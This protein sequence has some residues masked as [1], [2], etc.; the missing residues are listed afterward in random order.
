[1]LPG[2]FGKRSWTSGSV[3]VEEY[4]AFSGRR[5]LCGA[6]ACKGQSRNGGRPRRASSGSSMQ[7][8]DDRTRGRAPCASRFGAFLI[9]ASDG[10]LCDS[11]L[12]A[13]SKGRAR[14]PWSMHAD[15]LSRPITVGGGQRC[16]G[17]QLVPRT[18]TFGGGRTSQSA[19]T[20]HAVQ[21]PESWF[22]GW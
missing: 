9:I 21:L 10:L 6:V 2:G 13:C 1:M 3:G 19:A 22:L 11:C 4:S 14:T 16:T 12:A 8:V 20:T 18:D 17:E 15:D 5:A 7:W